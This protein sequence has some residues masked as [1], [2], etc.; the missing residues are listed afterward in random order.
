MK[1]IP[2]LRDL[3]ERLRRGR[4]AVT[5]RK[6]ERRLIAIERRED[7]VLYGFSLWLSAG[8][9]LVLS[10]ERWRA[11]HQTDFEDWLDAW[12]EFEALNALACYSWEHPDYVFPDL[13]EGE[14][15]FEATDL[16]HPLLP[17]NRCV[18]NITQRINGVL[19]CQR[20]KYGWKEHFSA[21]YWIEFRS[22][23]GW[24]SGPCIQ[25]PHRRLPR[26]RLNRH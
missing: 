25:R 8:T 19:C 12:A 15:T 10:S 11:G 16:G 20:L 6:L 13:L 1:Q 4:A 24:S 18:G 17:R 26:L 22:G 14:A 21:R 7:V 5:M 2:I 9:Q 3:V 23:F